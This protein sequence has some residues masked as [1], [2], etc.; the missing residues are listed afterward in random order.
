MSE[1]AFIEAIRTR[2]EDSASWLSYAGWLEERGHRRAELLRLLILLG[3][4]S[5]SPEQA[6]KC[7]G[8][9]ADLRKEVDGPWFHEIMG[10]RAGMPLRFRVEGCLQMGHIPPREM[11]DRAMTLIYGFLEAG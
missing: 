7:R 11:F 2:P 6:Q 4:E 9:F 1:Q 5:L 8:R 3:E 10:L